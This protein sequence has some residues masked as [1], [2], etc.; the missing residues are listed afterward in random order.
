MNDNS[1][2]QVKNKLLNAISA[3]ALERLRPLLERVDLPLGTVICGADEPITHVYFPEDAMASVVATTVDG[4]G[5][6]V[7]VIGSEGAVG[8]AVILGAETTPYETLIQLN[9][10]G[11]RLKTADIRTEFERQ[12]TLHGELLAFTQQFIVQI[13]QTALCNRLHSIE[14]RLSRWLLM[15]RD[16][17]VNDMMPLT[18]EFLSIMLGSNRTTVTLTAIEL[19]KLGLIR[20]SRGK[21]VITD[22]KGLEGFTCSCYDVIRKAY[23]SEPATLPDKFETAR[24]GKEPN[25]ASS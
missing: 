20:Y 1:H 14:Q 25:F 11:Y 18:Q 2:F 5:A 22:R 8:L 16:R 6:E 15:C 17:S 7:A 23:E 24:D 12:G 10:S 4:Q 19:Q 13:S 9:G 21:M 3:G